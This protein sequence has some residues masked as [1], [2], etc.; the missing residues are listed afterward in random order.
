MQ[1][2]YQL[3]NLGK[4]LKERYVK[5]WPKLAVLNGS[6]ITVYSTRYRRTFQSALALLYG[7]IPQEALTKI[8]ILE[9]QSMNFCFKDCGCPIT[10]KYGKYVVVVHV[11][12]QCT[13]LY[14]KG[15]YKKQC[16]IN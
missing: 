4:V 1:G 3:L 9:S 6:D 2:V 11:C 10:D 8:N 15:R 7:L 14:F 12:S 16:L 5:F 13:V